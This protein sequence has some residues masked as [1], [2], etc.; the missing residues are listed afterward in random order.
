[1]ER[2]GL[3]SNSIEAEWIGGT[4]G[5]ERGAWEDLDGAQRSRTR[6]MFAPR[7]ILGPPGGLDPS[8]FKRYVRALRRLNE[9]FRMTPGGSGENRS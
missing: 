7:I 6:R 3:I 2:N 5:G 4:G 9:V 1:M 8:E